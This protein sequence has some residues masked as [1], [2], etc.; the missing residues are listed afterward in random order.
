MKVAVYNTI[1]S[2]RPYF[3]SLRELY[4]LDEPSKR[5]VSLDL[6][7]PLKWQ[8]ESILE[9]MNLPEVSIKVQDKNESNKLSSMASSNKYNSI[10]RI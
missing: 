8:V 2:L 4:M 10:K 7:I 5:K 1:S 9:A 6:R 3:F